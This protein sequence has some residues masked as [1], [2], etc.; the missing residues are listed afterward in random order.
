MRSYC[1]ARQTVIPRNRREFPH[2]GS[3]WHVWACTHEAFKLSFYFFFL[4]QCLVSVCLLFL[5]EHAP[6]F[7][8]N[9]YSMTVPMYL[10][11]SQPFKIISFHFSAY[12][13]D[14]GLAPEIGKLPMQQFRMRES[15]RTWLDAHWQINLKT[16]CDWLNVSLYTWSAGAHRV[17]SPNFHLAEKNITSSDA[18]QVDGCVANDGVKT[19]THWKKSTMYCFV[20]FPDSLVCE[21]QLSEKA[22]GQELL[23]AVGIVTNLGCKLK[24]QFRFSLFLATNFLFHI[25]R[26]AEDF[27][28]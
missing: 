7:W 17:R 24:V 1:L 27:E 19:H 20:S 22:R 15:P 10:F 21:F 2:E 13:A 18:W 6:G 14:F 5:A 12:K 28:L 26:F 25:L 3:L 23:D 8:K 16:S 4:L 11:S 9:I